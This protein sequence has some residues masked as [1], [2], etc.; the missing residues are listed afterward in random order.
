[1]TPNREQTLCLRAEHQV[2]KALY[3]AIADVGTALD[4]TPFHGAE[5]NV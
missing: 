4:P 2:L 5:T 1:M 3:R